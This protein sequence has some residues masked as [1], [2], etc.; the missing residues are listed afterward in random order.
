MA[1]DPLNTTIIDRQD[2]T[3]TL[4]VFRLRPDSH[5]VPEFEAGQFITIGLPA[6]AEPERQVV[7]K[8]RRKGPRMVRRAYSIASSPDT[9]NYIE[10][11]LV[12]V[13]DGRLTP[14]LWELQAGDRLWID[15][16]TNGGFTLNGT[17]ADK[18]LV[19][20]STGTGLAPYISMLRACKGQNR[21][22]RFIVIHGA[23][24]EKE[25]GY[26]QELEQISAQ[27]PTVIYIPTVTRE[28]QGSDWQGLRGRVQVALE[29]QTYQRLV[30]ARLDP[31]SCLVFLCGNPAMITTVEK[32]LEARGFVTH[33]RDHPGNI[34]FE[35]YW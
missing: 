33:T 34:H 12:L 5:S 18:D 17:P 14:R 2:L 29:D 27:D 10:L 23:C 30:G 11:Y 15:D 19:M 3:E 31:S 16:K 13:K 4:A 6:L 22:R 26:R 7:A 20:V 21:W 25:L 8:G 28:P 1:N 24:Y 35:R 9:G 32:L